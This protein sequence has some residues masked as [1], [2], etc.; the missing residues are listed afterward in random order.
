VLSG[1]I[2]GYHDRHGGDKVTVSKVAP[3]GTLLWGT[4]GVQVSI[5]DRFIAAPKVVG[6]TDGNGDF[7][8]DPPITEVGILP[9]ASSR[10]VDAL[11]SQGFA[12]YAWSDGDPDILAQNVNPDGSLGP[13]AIFVDGFESGDTTQWSDTI[14]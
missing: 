13:G 5:E 4:D 14:P 10:L 8:W 2:P 11:S 1:R 12:A 9:T 3:D 7:V 6:T